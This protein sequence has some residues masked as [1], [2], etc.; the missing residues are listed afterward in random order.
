MFSPDLHFCQLC[1]I[2]PPDTFF[3]NDSTTD[4]HVFPLFEQILAATHAI[5]L[6]FPI[7]MTEIERTTF[8]GLGICERQDLQQVL[9]N[10]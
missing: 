7:R 8:E 2:V 1:R 4:S 3:A 10:R 5:V 6:I 9:R